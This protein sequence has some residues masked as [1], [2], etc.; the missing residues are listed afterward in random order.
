MRVRPRRAGERGEVGFTRDGGWGKQGAEEICS[1]AQQTKECTIHSL[2]FYKG[3]AVQLQNDRLCDITDMRR[4][5]RVR[6]AP[7]CA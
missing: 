7:E 4:A 3:G 2:M 1:Q 6:A 5:N